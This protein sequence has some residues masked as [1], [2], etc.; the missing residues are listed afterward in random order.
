MPPCITVRIKCC[1][2]ARE[3]VRGV[4]LRYA[5]ERNAD[6]LKLNV[7]LISLAEYF[8]GIAIFCAENLICQQVSHELL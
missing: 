2:D 8:Y 6:L 7:E 5:T 1:G 3:G 4:G